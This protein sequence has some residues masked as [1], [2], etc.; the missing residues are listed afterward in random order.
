[1]KRLL[2]IYIFVVAHAAFSVAQTQR[3]GDGIDDVM[4]YA[5]YA[6]LFA[7]KTAGLE[8]RHDW[9]QLAATAVGSWVVS[10]GIAYV[11]KHN[12]DEWRPDHTDQHSFPSG[13]TT[14][15][16]AGATALHK[17]FGHLSP[18]VSVGGYTVAVLT[19]ADRLRRDRHHWHDVCVGAA[20]GFGATQ[21]TY[22]VSDLLFPRKQVGIAF[23]GNSLDV[24]LRW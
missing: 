10:A 8:S 17:E 20:I 2:L 16:F 11:L 19:A 24:S 21:L 4:Q 9:P 1:M 6:A 22:Y 3:H 23:T 7:M 14:I 13:H 18:W 5:P 15:A 12:I